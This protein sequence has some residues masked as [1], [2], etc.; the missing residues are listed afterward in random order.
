[1]G[2]DPGVAA[3]RARA[4]ALFTPPA[5]SPGGKV[6]EPRQA[7]GGEPVEEDRDRRRAD[8]AREGGW[9]ADAPPAEPLTP[10]LSRRERWWL[11][12]RERLPVWLQLRCGVEPRAVVALAAVLVLAGGFAAYHF[13]AGR[14]QTVRA[15]SAE[16]P[17]A[18]ASAP[19]RGSPGALPG[20]PAASG[21]GRRVVVDVVGKVREPGIYRLAQGARVADAIEA[22]G[23]ARPGAETGTLN[24]A[25]VL[26]DGE[27]IVVGGAAP[28]EAGGTGGAGT[29]GTGSGAVGASAGPGAGG[30]GGAGAGPVSLSSATAEQLDALP[31]VGPVLARHIIDYREQNGGFRSVGQLREVNGIGQRRFADLRPLVQP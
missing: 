7:A 3:L 2:A 30:V 10:S 12:V 24:R 21:T 1:M 25:R 27:Q 28:V 11:A 22:A 14:P 31:G 4:E 20:A 23:G 26:G 6:L 9:E 15:P 5:P 29:A 13:W 18:P 16:P 8:K 19:A 17:P